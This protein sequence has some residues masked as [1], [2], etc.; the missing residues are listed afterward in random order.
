MRASWPT[1]QPSKK[2]TIFFWKRVCEVKDLRL[3]VEVEVEVET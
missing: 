3:E 2:I 1:A